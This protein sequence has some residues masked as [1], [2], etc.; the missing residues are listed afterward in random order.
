MFTDMVGYTALAQRNEPLS[1]ALL[2]EQKKLVR[3]ILSSHNGREIK[4]MGDAFLIEFNSALDAVK[5]ASAIQQSLSEFNQGRPSDEQVKLRIGLHVGDVIHNQ[6]DV[7]GDAVNVASRI[8]PLAEPGGVCMSQQ[9]YDHIGNK[10]EFPIV[11]VGAHALKNIE[12]RIEVYKVVLPWD[13]DSTQP[14]FY[15][16]HECVEC[17]IYELISSG[18]VL[19]DGPPGSG[20]S[21]LVNGMMRLA[22][23]NGQ[24]VIF[25]T[26]GT[27]PAEIQ[28]RV[29]NMGGEADNVKII[30]CYG[31]KNVDTIQFEMPKL[32]LEWVGK[33]LAENL[34]ALENPYVVFDSLDPLP[35]DVGET[36]TFKFLFA[37]CRTCRANSIAGSC[38]VTGEA[39]SPQFMSMLK[40]AFDAV[41][42]LKLETVGRGMERTLQIQTLKGG[43]HSTDFFPFE[44]VDDGILVGT[45][46]YRSKLRLSHAEP[47]VLKFEARSP[48]SD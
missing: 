17:S 43:A 32:D 15:A 11:S 20:K 38:V 44:I 46:D 2:E 1:V 12:G 9:V 47:H 27:A 26:T 24:P 7:Y 34:S 25:I 21:S 16:E 35:M 10:F 8:E 4:T 28:K 22:L 5:C 23:Q 36:P 45:K 18:M 19:I 39:H 40:T 14:S 37:A 41:I 30:D 48:A 29:R 6:G 31:G 42:Q 33:M 3:P 13:S